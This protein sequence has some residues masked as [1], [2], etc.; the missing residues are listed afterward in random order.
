MSLEEI[1]AKIPKPTKKQK[2]R[3]RKRV[4]KFACRV[5]KWAKRTGCYVVS[6]GNTLCLDCGELAFGHRLGCR[7][8][9][10]GQLS[11]GVSYGASLS[12]GEIGRGRRKP[13]IQ[14]S[15]FISYRDLFKRLQA[16]DRFFDI[17][18]RRELT[19]RDFEKAS[20]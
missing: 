13:L 8:M 20:Q 11:K 5:K 14:E 7:C 17:S 9:K 16:G 4:R 1:F 3:N 12:T 19:C 6:S 15:D 18:E 2:Y 10:P